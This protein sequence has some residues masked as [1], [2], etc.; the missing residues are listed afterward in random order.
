MASKTAASDLRTKIKH[1]RRLL[2]SLRGLFS[3]IVRDYRAGLMRRSVPDVHARSGDALERIL[4]AHYRAVGADFLG[5]I[6]SELSTDVQTTDEERTTIEVEAERAFSKRAGRQAEVIS[7]TTQG[8]VNDG[9]LQATRLLRRPD[10]T[11]A[12]E[13]EVIALAVTRLASSLSRRAVTIATF[14]TQWAAESSKVIEVTVLLDATGLIEVK[15]FQELGTAEKVWRSQGDSRVRT[16]DFNHL[17]ADGQRVPADQPFTVSGE[18]LMWPGDTSMGASIG[19]VINC[20][21]SAIY[22]AASVED[23]RRMIGRQIIEDLTAFAFPKTESRIVVG[24]DPE[25]DPPEP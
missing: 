23:L 13:D 7:R 5:L 24:V 25:F 10:G 12:P 16:G 18:S 22:E 2:S 20:R 17:S 21:C 14:E 8:Q 3:A 4:L 1:E 6:G 15:G 11:G 19:N 9:V